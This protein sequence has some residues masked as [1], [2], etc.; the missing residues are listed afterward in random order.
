MS[1]FSFQAFA[2]T[3]AQL[4]SQAKAMD[5]TSRQQ[6]LDELSKRGISESQARQMARMRGIDFD[7]FLDNY[8]GNSSSTVGGSK[9]PASNL[10]PLGASIVRDTVILQKE[11]I[12]AVSPTTSDSVD[13]RYFGYSIFQNNPFL[14]KQ[15]LTGNIDEGYLVAPGDRLRITI[16]GDNSLETEVEVDLNGN[17]TIPGFGVVQAG[18]NTFKTLRERLKIYFG[19]YFLGLLSTQQSTF[20]DVSLT[21]IRPVQVTVVGESNAPGAHLISGMASVLNALYASGGIK[22]SGSLRSIKIYRNNK[23]Y[24]EV[25]LYSYLTSGALDEDIRLTSNDLIF[26]PPRLSSV[27]LDGEVKNAAI[28]ELKPGETLADLLRFSGGIPVT[29]SKQTVTIQR[30]QPGTATSGNLTFDRVLTSVSLLENGTYTLQDGDEVRLFPILEKV[31]NQVT[32][33]GHVNQPGNYPISDFPDLRSLILT[34]GKNIRPNTYLG[35]VDVYKESLQGQ[36]SF[37]TYNLESVLKGAIPVVLESQDSVK[38]YSSQEVQGQQLVYISGFGISRPVRDS[39]DE[40]EN[41]RKVVFWRNNLSVYDLVFQATSWEELEFQRQLLTSRI[42]VRSFD[43]KTNQFKVTTY[44]L[45]RLEELQK[46]FLQP[47]DEV[48][49]F[50]RAVTEVLFPKVKI[51]GYVTRPGE[52]QL[53]QGMTV[54]D[55]ILQA[56]G[57]VEYADQH[58]VVINRERFDYNTGKLSER[59]EVTL[60]KDY[61][62]GKTTSSKSNFVLEHNDVL[63]VRKKEGVE[64]LRSVAIEGAVRFPGT[65]VLEERLETFEQLIQKVGGL[66]SD[67]YLKASYITRADKVLAVNL[68]RTKNLKQAFF[69]EGDQVFIADRAGTVEVLGA[70][71]NEAAFVWK[72][73]RRAKYYLT[74]SGGKLHKEGGKAYVVQSNGLSQ[75][76]NLF[77]NPQVMPDSQIMVNQKPDK[78]KPTTPFLDSFVRVLSVVTGALT[79]IILVE[80][81]N[82]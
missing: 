46:T 51:N 68:D 56:G 3:E 70:V 76:V 80:N 16:F 18:G 74:H 45:D 54:E 37:I 55:A 26:I 23:L 24:K 82:N 2:Q 7:S 67:A 29:A 77:R 81:L 38:V 39:V 17:L 28:Y 60:D 48:F 64:V 57:F 21:Q 49:L 30:I 50:S 34:A 6:A 71:E 44:S 40:G 19:K 75:Q 12:Q 69:Q 11:L 9:T 62:L 32:L 35:K 59:F 73:G 13:T 66:R 36:R 79:T 72:E 52:V 22:P 65:V 43:A 8:L 25:D 61:L 31:I 1:F 78:E 14:S 33:S 47:K 5:I 15:Y 53:A 41:Y 42:D 4:A 58:T 27:T 20:L 63:S 10:P